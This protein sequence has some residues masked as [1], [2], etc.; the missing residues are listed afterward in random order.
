MKNLLKP[1]M[2]MAAVL[3]VYDVCSHKSA[4][5]EE[6]PDHSYVDFSSDRS[7]WF[8]RTD[9][10]NRQVA[11]FDFFSPLDPT[12]KVKAYDPLTMYELDHAYEIRE[13]GS[14]MIQLEELKKLYDPY[15][16]YEV[17]DDMLHIRHTVYDKLVTDR[18]G[19]RAPTIEY[20]K[21]VWDV[22][23][24]LTGNGAKDAGVYDYE[25]Y[26]PVEGGRNKPEINPVDLNAEESEEQH[27][28]T[29]SKGGVEVKDGDYYVPLAE[30]MEVMGKVS[31]EEEGYLA[32]Q[33]E[34][35]PDVTES[36]NRSDQ[37]VKIDDLVVPKPSNTWHGGA[38]EEVDPDYTWADYMDDV[39][40]GKRQT[41]WLWKSF[42]MPS[43]NDFKD[44]NGEKVK[45]DADRIVP[46]S[47][48]VPQDYD[49]EKTR[50]TYMLHGGTGNEHTPTSRLIKN[51]I[52]V[53]TYA[54]D[55][56]YIL[57]SPNGWTQNPLWRQGQ[58]LQ[59]FERSFDYTLNQFPVDPDHLF[60]TG[61]S[62]GGRGTLELA[63]RFPDRFQ[64]MAPTAPKITDRA[65]GGGTMVNIEGND[66]DLRAVKDLPALVVQG[67]ADTT[68]SFKVQ[69]GNGEAPGSI[70]SSVIPKLENA[71]YVTVEQGG[72]SYSYAAVLEMIFQF[73]EEQISVN[74]ETEA[75]ET[76]NLY[77]NSEQAR[78][79]QEIYD[80][81]VP[82][83]TTD[84]TTMVAAGD[85]EEMYGTDL[86]VYP[87]HLYDSD[88]DQP[89][90]Y[91]TLLH[92]GQSLNFTVGETAYRL[93]MERYQED[94]KV[95]R[96]GAP[97]DED[98]LETAPHFTTA[99]YEK[100]GEIYVPAK[101]VLSAFELEVSVTEQSVWQKNRTA[102]LAS[103]SGLFLA[104]LGLGGYFVRRKRKRHAE[105]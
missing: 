40:D 56:N 99:P 39:A 82:T 23:F 11:F 18:H 49:A 87:V 97:S 16:D 94:A 8:F 37:E 51:D 4:A 104:I 63:T 6:L 65:P 54:E 13:D 42:Y 7:T 92:N 64:A 78:I 22:T 72:H 57:L 69:I 90:D 14:L 89:A 38:L 29:F 44:E 46:F 77:K 68:T 36:V 55:Y 83:E 43:G 74:Q 1:V 21:K 60:I 67:T 88:P 93:N 66:Y 70:V 75:F 80:L 34:G 98:K 86:K 58:A 71:T 33:A 102:F 26:L 53:E 12:V 50:L 10:G 35:M 105:E 19:Q 95:T 81:E 41:G 76:L 32:I 3:M 15:F 103:G 100:D 30:M 9:G 48:Y 28:F 52:P 84:E 25:E 27:P 61:N 47:L 62:L 2:L 79:D 5:A 17:T 20:T 96:S 45:L 73:F 85:L 31:F 59:S 91:W 101:E 24:D